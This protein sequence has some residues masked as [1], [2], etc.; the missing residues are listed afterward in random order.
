MLPF[1]YEKGDVDVTFSF[2]L[3]WGVGNCAWFLRESAMSLL[4]F[5]DFF[6]LENLFIFLTQGEKASLFLFYP[7]GSLEG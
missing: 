5:W 3:P 7:R 1:G 6:K 2:V 4:E